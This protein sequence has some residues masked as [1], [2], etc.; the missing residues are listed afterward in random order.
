MKTKTIIT[1]VIVLIIIVGAVW[2][3]KIQ[4]AKPG[5]HDTFAQCLKD[6]GV[7]FY[8]AFW[9]PHCQA[10]KKLFGRSAKFLPYIECST[11]DGQNQLKSCTDVGVKSYPTWMFPDGTTTTGEQT[12][13]QLAE[14]SGCTETPAQ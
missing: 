6:K 13:A 7:K 9:C 10:Q 4:S 2:F 14:K 8:G 12:F 1:L 11:A 5:P 3:A